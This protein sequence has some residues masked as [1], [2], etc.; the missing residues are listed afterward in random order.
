[1]DDGAGLARRLEEELR[2]GLNGTE[3]IVEGLA[4][5]L[6]GATLRAPSVEAD[7]VPPRWLAPLL[8]RLHEELPAPLTLLG[9]ATEMG[10]PAARLSS[11]FQR[12]TGRSLGDYRRELRVEWVRRLLRDRSRSGESL[13]E[14]S[15]AAGF[16][17]QAHCTRVFKAATGWTPGRYR[18]AVQRGAEPLALR[19]RVSG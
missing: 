3:L 8:E 14:I 6:L 10:M 5:E 11:A 7:A 19:R 18:A 16:A 15:I 9:L 1:V 4:L 12:H 17:D 13:A 2:Q